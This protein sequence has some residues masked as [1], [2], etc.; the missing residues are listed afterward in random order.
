MGQIFAYI[1][2]KGGV[3]DDSALELVSAA[4]KIDAGASVTAI[5]AGSGGD[6]DAVTDFAVDLHPHR[7]FIHDDSGFIYLGP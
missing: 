4:K 1:T 2:Y 7:N 6:C 5:V 3:A